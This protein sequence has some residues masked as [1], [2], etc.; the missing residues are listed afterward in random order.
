RDGEGN[1][2]PVPFMELR[3]SGFLEQLQGLILLYDKHYQIVKDELGEDPNLISQAATPRVAVSNIETATQQ[4]AFATDYYYD[5]YKNCM[6]DTA[7]KISCLLKNSVTYGSKVYRRIIGQEDVDGR[8]FSTRVNMLPDAIQIAKFEAILNQAIISTPE[9]VLFVDPFQLMRVAKEDVKLAEALFRHG[10]KSMLVHQR[11][12]AEE[13]QRQTIEGQ[14]KSAQMAE[15]S[16]QQTEELKGKM[17]IG[18]ARATGEYQN[19]N[20]VLSA[21]MKMYEQ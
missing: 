2:L 15:Q 21:I 6:A 18:K 3:N 11:K 12:V 17:E 5:A 4:G 7:R 19:K 10:Q 1:P 9:L 20:A 13:N 16:R 8:I 14:I